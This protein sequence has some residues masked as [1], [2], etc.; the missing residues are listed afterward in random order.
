MSEVS[1]LD[2]KYDERFPKVLRH[3][4]TVHCV[5]MSPIQFTYQENL[6]RFDYNNNKLQMSLE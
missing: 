2:V 5:G 3:Y 4:L 1:L 6:V